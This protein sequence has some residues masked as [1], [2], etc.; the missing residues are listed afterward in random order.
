MKVLPSKI[1]KKALEGTKY[2]NMRPLLHGSTA[3]AY[4]QEPN[5]S[6]LL[7][8]TK[9]EPKLHLLGGLVEESLLTPRALYKYANLPEKTVLQQ[10]LLTTL[11][12]PQ[13]TL[14]NILLDSSRRLVQLLGHHVSEHK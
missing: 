7:L 4:S 13:A 10:Q 9:L 2:Q 1:A 11:T 5:L 8:V 6:K 14:S 12:I 3:I